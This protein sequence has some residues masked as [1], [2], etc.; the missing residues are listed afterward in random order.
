MGEALQQIPL[1]LGSRQTLGREDF[2]IGSCN[3]AA[4][5]MIDRWPEWPAPL[6]IISGPP[7]SGKSHLAAVW[8]ER[9]SAETIRPEMLLSRTAEQIS[10]AGRHLV[11]DGLDP[12]LGDRQAETTLFHLYNIFW[13]EK[14]NILAT[15]RM[16][17]AQTQFAV[18]DL[19]SRVRASLTVP[20]QPPDDML[21]GSVLIKQ[22]SDRQMSVNN[23][24]IQYIL[25]RMERSFD[26]ARTI[27]DR[28]D[29]LALARKRGISVP[30]LRQVLAEL[31]EE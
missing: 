17:P 27:V 30:L 21:L 2:L 1:D 8:R 25:P 10:E 19:A 18:A 28:A 13:S 3:V 20:I 7:A 14:R 12:W 31:Q 11:I 4:V 29:K 15:M 24:V 26:A 22:F 16:T 23:D 9:A 5:S 6:M